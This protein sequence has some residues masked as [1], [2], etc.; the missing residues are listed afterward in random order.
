MTGFGVG[1]DHKFYL[2]ECLGPKD[3]SWTFRQHECDW[4][5]HSVGADRSSLSYLVPRQ[6]RNFNLVQP[7]PDGFLLASS[8]CKFDGDMT[9]ANGLMCDFEGHPTRTLLLGDGIQKIHSTTAGEIWV[10][11]FDEGVFGNLGWNRPIGRSGLV[12]FDG[13]GNLVYA[14]DPIS[15]PDSIVDCYAMNVTTL[16]DTWCY[17]YTQFSIVHVSED[18]VVRHWTCPV[19]GASEIAVWRDM[20]AMPSG[21]RASDWSLLRLR[22]NGVAE[23]VGSLECV[24]QFGAMFAPTGATCRGDAVWFFRENKVYRTALRDIRV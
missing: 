18:R 17:Y 24:D 23:M 21:Y 9:A 4:L 7:T 14:F 1:P 2:V 8:R 3:E 13:E 12:R 5:V 10:S 6:R 22:P 11:Y 20:V 16:K 15:G 19:G